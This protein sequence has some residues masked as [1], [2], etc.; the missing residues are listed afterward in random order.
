MCMSKTISSLDGVSQDRLNS[1]RPQTYRTATA[2]KPL[3]SIHSSFVRAQSVTFLNCRS[4]KLLFIGICHNVFEKHIP[5]EAARVKECFRRTHGAATR[6]SQGPEV[7][8][9]RIK[10]CPQFS[11]RS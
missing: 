4:V 10:I 5:H 2:A 1:Q 8:G 9:G 7:D 11:R 3:T 6:L